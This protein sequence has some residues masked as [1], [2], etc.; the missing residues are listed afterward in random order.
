MVVE[1]GERLVSH[2][3][4]ACVIVTLRPP[5][6]IVPVRAVVPVFTVNEMATVPAPPPEAGLTVIHD[7]PLE[8]DHPHPDAALT[9]TE[10]VPAEAVTESVVGDTVTVHGAPACVT[11]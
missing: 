4:P 3:A 11:V 10:D 5:T 9:L 7:A 8:A 6:V 2:G 1:V